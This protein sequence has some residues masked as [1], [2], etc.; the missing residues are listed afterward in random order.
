VQEVKEDK[1]IFSKIPFIEDLAGFCANKTKA[2]RR[3]QTIRS[4]Y[5]V[6]RPK[7]NHAFISA[8]DYDYPDLYAFL[9]KLGRE[10]SGHLTPEKTVFLFLTDEI[11]SMS[12]ETYNAT[13]GEFGKGISVDEYYKMMR[14]K[15]IFTPSYHTHLIAKLFRDA[16]LY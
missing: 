3:P 2:K 7:L 12:H 6:N 4:L 5:Q 16:V 9:K 13:V 10:G 14:I 15:G 1:E 8:H 11:M